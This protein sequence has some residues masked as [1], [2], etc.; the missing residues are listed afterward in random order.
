MNVLGKNDAKSDRA[1]GVANALRA[2]RLVIRAGRTGCSMIKPELARE[3][4]TSFA[5]DFYWEHSLTT[6]SAA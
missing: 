3:G 4:T 2:P 6:V 5:E 1:L